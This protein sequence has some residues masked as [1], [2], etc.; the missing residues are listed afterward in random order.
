MSEYDSLGRLKYDPDLLDCHQGRYTED[1]LA[2]MCAM[3]GSMSLTD[4]GLAV[5]RTP[6]AVAVKL[7]SLKKQGLYEH[8]RN[9]GVLD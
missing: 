4:I 8:Y 5:G 6:C 2:Y 3:H 9:M 1:D 7:G